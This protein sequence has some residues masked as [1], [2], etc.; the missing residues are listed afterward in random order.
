M[1]KLGTSAI[2][3]KRMQSQAPAPR[4]K[5]KEKVKASFT[6]Q[7]KL[8]EEDLDDIEDMNSEEI[9]KLLVSNGILKPRASDEID[10][11]EVG[12]EIKA[13]K[14]LYLF[15][16]GSCFRRNIHFI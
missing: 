14:S 9:R 15:A 16:R 5:K 1:K 10:L 11:K 3:L 4:K 8:R 6:G 7:Q 13:D 2:E 12:P